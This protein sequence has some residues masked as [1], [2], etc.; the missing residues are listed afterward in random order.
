MFGL[1]RFSCIAAGDIPFAFLQLALVFRLLRFS[2][3]A[4]G[5]VPFAFL[6]GPRHAHV[7][8]GILVLE[9]HD[10]CRD[11]KRGFARGTT[12]G[13]DVLEVL[14]E[15]GCL[16]HVGG[17]FGGLLLLGHYHEADLPF[18]RLRRFRPRSH[19]T[20]FGGVRLR[21]LERLQFFALRDA[22]STQG[23]DTK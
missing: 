20:S 1:L 8:A 17:L 12:A 3:I 2:C 4:A 19:G 15:F 10:G 9:S 13:H 16:R 23:K 21:R 6:A 7:V 22:P 18:V 5:D 11:P 14:A